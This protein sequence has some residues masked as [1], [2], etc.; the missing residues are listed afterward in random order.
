QFDKMGMHD[1]VF[2]SWS[3]I[4]S[5]VQGAC[6]LYHQQWQADC[7][8]SDDDIKQWMQD[9]QQCHIRS[10]ASYY[11]D[12]SPYI[13]IYNIGPHPNYDSDNDS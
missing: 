6:G 1:R 13:S 8:P 11:D 7:A 5:Q 12:Y 4:G 10:D 9:I 2:T 3:K